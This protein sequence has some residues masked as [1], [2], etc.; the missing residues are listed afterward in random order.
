M[1]LLKIIGSSHRRGERKTETDI[2]R[3]GEKDK[4]VSSVL[5]AYVRVSEIHDRMTVAHHVYPRRIPV[6]VTF[7]D[8]YVAS[9]GEREYIGRIYRANSWTTLGGLLPLYLFT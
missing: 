2:G 8:G 1:R 6:C 7:M 9:G 3:A 5:C 4:P